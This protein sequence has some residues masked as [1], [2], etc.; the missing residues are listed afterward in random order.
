VAFIIYIINF[1]SF[2]ATLVFY[3]AIFPR[4]AR[5]TARTL[6]MRDKLS[7]GQVSKH[8]YDIEESMEKNRI[9]NI[10]TVRKSSLLVCWPPSRTLLTMLVVQVHYTVG[11]GVVAGLNVALLIPLKDHPLVDNFAIVMCVLLYIV[12]TPTLKFGRMTVYAVVVGGWWCAFC[13]LLQAYLC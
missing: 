4:L 13:L 9:S 8:E 5:C 2:G 6:E 1:T 12:H 7:T 10:S 3:M 11:Y